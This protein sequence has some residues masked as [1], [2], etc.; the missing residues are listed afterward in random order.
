MVLFWIV[1]LVIE[2]WLKISK[3]HQWWIF[4]AQTRRSVSVN[5]KIKS[6]KI[7]SEVRWPRLLLIRNFFTCV[8][9][10]VISLWEKDLKR[11]CNHY[12]TN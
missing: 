4:E 8:L 3:T 6:Y 5:N 1:Q 10:N 9:F 7:E 12:V 11:Y 2:Q